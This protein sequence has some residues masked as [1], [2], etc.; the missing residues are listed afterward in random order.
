MFFRLNTGEF[1]ALKIRPI[2]S[3]G[4]HIGKGEPPESSCFLCRWRTTALC[5]SNGTQK[6]MNSKNGSLVVRLSHVFGIYD[7]T[8]FLFPMYSTAALVYRRQEVGVDCSSAMDAGYLWSHLFSL[9]SGGGVYKAG[10]ILWRLAR[11]WRTDCGFLL[12]GTLPLLTVRKV[13]ILWWVRIP[14]GWIRRRGLLMNGETMN[15]DFAE[16]NRL[17]CSPCSESLQ[18]PVWPLWTSALKIGK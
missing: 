4:F 18:E 17:N 14:A 1:R 15:W 10:N 11:F 7:S 16:C 5:S 6:G 13:Q 3:C 9:W 2:M 12:V 8:A